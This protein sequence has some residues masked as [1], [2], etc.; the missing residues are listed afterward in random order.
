MRHRFTLAWVA[1]SVP[2]VMVLHCTPGSDHFT[3]GIFVGSRLLSEPLH[4]LS[5]DREARGLDAWRAASIALLSAKTDWSGTAIPS[6]ML[7]ISQMREEEP[8]ISAHRENSCDDLTARPRVVHVF[9]DDCVA[10]ETA[11]CALS[12]LR[13]TVA[14]NSY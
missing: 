14:V 6:M 5:D 12:R 4:A 7:T 10:R 8:E 13:A 3:S 1:R 9:E 2:R 11:S